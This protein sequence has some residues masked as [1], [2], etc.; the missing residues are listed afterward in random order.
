MSI[1]S[2]IEALKR[3]AERPGTPHEGEV[4]REMLKRLQSAAVD[5]DETE[6]SENALSQYLKRE[7]SIDEFIRRCKVT[8]CPCGSIHDVGGKCGNWQ[9][10][11]EIQ[12]EIR[13]KFQRGDRIVYNYWAYPKDCPGKVAAYVKLKPE[14]G[15]Y[16]WGWLSIKFDHLK[17][18]RQVP[19]WDKDGLCI[20]HAVTEMV[21][22]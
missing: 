18:A 20:K 4:A 8:R 15:T 5:I 3:L 22:V 17:S 9:R 21:E 14:N 2:K 10:H 16:P 19:V 11:L 12:T 7:I 6:D 13:A 1:Q